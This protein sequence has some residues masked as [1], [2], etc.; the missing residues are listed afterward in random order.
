MDKSSLDKFSIKGCAGYITDT[1]NQIDFNAPMLSN[2][3][4]VEAF[5]VANGYDPNSL[6]FSGD[7]KELSDLKMQMGA[8]VGLNFSA[9]T[10]EYDQKMQ[11]ALDEISNIFSK[12]KEKFKEEFDLK[13][14][15]TLEATIG[16]ANFKIKEFEDNK[17]KMQ[18]QCNLLRL[19]ESTYK[20]KIEEI[21]NAHGGSDPNI[22]DSDYSEFEKA[23]ENLEGCSKKANDLEN[24]IKSTESDII[25]FKKVATDLKS[26]LA[27]HGIEV[28][29]NK[30]IEFEDKEKEDRPKQ[31]QE[32]NKNQGQIKNQ[33]QMGQQPLNIYFQQPEYSGAPAS[34]EQEKEEV[35]KVAKTMTVDDKMT[36]DERKEKLNE[37]LDKSKKSLIENGKPYILSDEETL[38]LQSSYKMFAF[39]KTDEKML[40]QVV[41][42]SISNKQQE[43]SKPGAM[44]DIRSAI[45]H[46]I[47]EIKDNELDA[48]VENIYGNDPNNV[49]ICNEKVS[50]SSRA[51]LS[52]LG[53]RLNKKI[54]DMFSFIEDD[55]KAATLK[56]PNVRAAF[57]E[58]KESLEKISSLLSSS[59]SLK[60]TSQDI[61]LDTGS[62]QKDDIKNDVKLSFSIKQA[63]FGYDENHFKVE[64]TDEFHKQLQDGIC[65]EQELARN[66]EK[67]YR[68]EQEERARAVNSRNRENDERGKF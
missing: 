31:N 5:C 60:G 27:E 48:F 41:E 30:S 58:D 59:I 21:R 42:A 7:D 34:M 56:D 45:K 1:V 15:K 8:Q 26:K 6:Q 29:I 67:T 36:S 50:D 2:K 10:Q 52:V 53:S 66:I 28:D 17:D 20:A 65:D 64:A 62:M 39:S 35:K 40:E 54:G 57:N 33:E 32:R 44:D 51:I 3:M 43:L 46:I 68:E 25:A 55:K 23:K 38:I 63:L 22:T 24:R 11:E 16:I 61:Q 37:I 14:R 19:E 13:F 12:N 4:D 47:P 9:G 49:T 18:E